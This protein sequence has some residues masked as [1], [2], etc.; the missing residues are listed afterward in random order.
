MEKDYLKIAKKDLSY[1]NSERTYF[2]LLFNQKRKKKYFFYISKRYEG[3][4]KLLPFYCDSYNRRKDSF[5][6]EKIIRIFLMCKFFSS[7][8]QR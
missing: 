3:N 7:L 4:K 6:L 2:V 5:V 1:N 8:L